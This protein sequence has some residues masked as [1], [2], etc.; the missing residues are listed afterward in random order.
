M[1]NNSKMKYSIKI[2]KYKVQATIDD[3]IPKVIQYFK[4]NG[5][6]LDLNISEISITKDDALLKLMLPNSGTCDVVMYL[7]DRS[8]FNSSSFGL[9]FNVSPTLRGI[10]LA[11]DVVDDKVDYTWK[12]MCH[13]IMHT[14]FFKFNLRNLDPMDGMYVNGIWQPYYKNEDLTATDGNFARAWSIL[15]PYILPTPPVPSVWTQVEI[16]RSVGD[17]NETLGILNASN[18]GAK[19]SCKTIELP[20]KQNQNN[21]SCIPTG[22]YEVK[23]TFSLRLLR[24]T[25]EIQGVKDRTGIRIHPANFFFD[26]K[27]CIALGNNMIDLNGDGVLDITNSKLTL[28]AFEDFMNRKSFTLKIQ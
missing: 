18:N 8:A 16:I 1:D 12:S 2:F 23:W 15:K 27:G 9:A 17:N 6:D 22:T 4:E 10:Y 19:F 28:K 5:I 26:L 7:Y 21:I 14:L 24:Y 3:D 13:E 20:W 25:Y 11:T